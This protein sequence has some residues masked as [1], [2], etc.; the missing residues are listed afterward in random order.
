MTLDVDDVG[1]KARARGGASFAR[2][3]RRIGVFRMEKVERS[4]LILKKSAEKGWA[5]NFPL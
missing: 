1:G 2:F 4:I 5:A 3:S